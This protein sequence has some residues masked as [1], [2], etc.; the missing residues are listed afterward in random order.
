MWWDL[1]EYYSVCVSAR[2][3]DAPG[4][5]GVVESVEVEAQLGLSPSGE[6]QSAP[7]L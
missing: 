1:Y 3:S 7:A 2:V 5:S 6:S 4:Q